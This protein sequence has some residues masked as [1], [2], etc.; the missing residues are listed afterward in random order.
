LRESTSIDDNSHEIE[1]V[2][3]SVLDKISV[4]DLMQCV[5]ELPN[6]YRTVFNLYAI[7]GYSHA[8]IA[9][10]LNITVETSRTQFM[11]ARL[12]LQKSVQSLNNFE[13]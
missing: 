12:I 11:K 4:D 13:R 7:E 10:S 1:D 9:N 5:T 2:D 8:E 3:I 6:G